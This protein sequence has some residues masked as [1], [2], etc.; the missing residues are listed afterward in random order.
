MDDLVSVE[1]VFNQPLF[2]ITVGCI[3]P[4][5]SNLWLAEQKHLADALRQLPWAV[6]SGTRFYD[7]CYCGEADL[8]ASKKHNAPLHD[9]WSFAKGIFKKNPEVN[10]NSKT[11]K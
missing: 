2:E 1:P 6:R 3:A 5:I 8:Y 4:T 11:G 7:L 10:H 9:E